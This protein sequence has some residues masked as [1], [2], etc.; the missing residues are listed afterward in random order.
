MIRH[1]K[2]MINVGGSDTPA[3]GTDFDGMDGDFEIS[4]CSKMQLLF[5]A[6]EREGFTMEEIEKIAYKNVERVIKEV[7]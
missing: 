7:F 2:H 3:I 6:M 4:E 1:V 5:E